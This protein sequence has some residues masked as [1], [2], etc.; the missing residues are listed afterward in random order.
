MANVDT[1]F[2]TLV[3]ATSYAPELRRPELRPR[4]YPRTDYVELS[5]IINC[6][7][8]D[9]AIYD[10]SA[11][12]R[13]WRRLER[14]FRLDFHLAA[15]G[16]RQAA[17]YDVVLLM[18][19][20]VAI[21]YMMLQKMLG[22][23]AATVCVSHHSSERQAAWI[24][25]GGLFAD[26]DIVVS[27]ARAQRDFL[28]E[29]F[30]VPGHRIRYVPYAID[31][32]FFTPGEEPGESGFVVSAGGIKGR[33]YGLLFE[34]VS[35]LP[36]QVGI[37]AGGR[38]YALSAA[39]KLPPPPRNVEFLPPTDSAGMRA[40]YRRANVVVVPLSSQRRDAAGCT[41]VLEAMACKK[42]V[43][44]S[45]T[46]GIIEYV[47]DG[48]TGLVAGPDDPTSMR[49]AILSITSCESLSEKLAAV[50]REQV[51]TQFSFANLVQGLSSAVR[52]AAGGT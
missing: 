49:E 50:A 24:R 41:V 20:Q 13:T 27:W 16:Y 22:R 52:E 23:R 40:L 3:L 21:P 34:A 19:E 4:E 36:L 26:V 32:S 2:R 35:D 28:V 45:W 29:K 6:D 42:P 11:V 15:L 33:N 47:S 9:Y 37:A 44:V 7:I 51:E 14:K 38:C 30:R 12:R 43:I 39:G 46:S 17:K 1:M 5:R 31:E 25:A 10:D 8:L 48:V 18:S